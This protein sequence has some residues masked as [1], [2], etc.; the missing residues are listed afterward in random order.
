MNPFYEKSDK[1]Q[2]LVNELISGPEVKADNTLVELIKNT[3]DE[4]KKEFGKFQEYWKTELKN[5]AEN[6]IYVEATTWKIPDNT[7][8]TCNYIT[9]AEGG[10]VGKR[11]KIKDLYSNINLNERKNTF[12]GKVTFN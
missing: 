12:N 1:F 7:V 9:P 5:F 10:L 8:K 6:P 3:C 2:T 11:K 4:L